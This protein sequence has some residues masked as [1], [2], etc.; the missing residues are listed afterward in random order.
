MPDRARIMVVEDDVLVGWG[1]ERLLYS[2][3]FAAV[4]VV[5]SVEQALEHLRY[6]SPDVVLL[7]LRLRGGNSSLPVAD[8]LEEVGIPFVFLT[9]R[10]RDEISVRHRERPYLRKPASDDQLLETLRSAMGAK[11]KLLGRSGSAQA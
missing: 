1:Y 11:S 7:D 8:R 9:G 10:D 5:V 3:G 4:K 6:S 2:T